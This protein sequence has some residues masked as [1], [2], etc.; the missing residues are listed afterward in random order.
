MKKF[1]YFTGF[2]TIIY[3]ISAMSSSAKAQEGYDISVRNSNTLPLPSEGKVGGI[4][5]QAIESSQN[6]R[7]LF[8]PL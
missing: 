2:C 5:G 4:L 3:M 8:L 6:G 1:D 7:L